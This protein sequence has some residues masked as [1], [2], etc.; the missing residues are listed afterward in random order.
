[1]NDRARLQESWDR[2]RGHLNRAL[3]LLPAVPAESDDARVSRYYELIEHNE[4]ELA[5]DELEGL[6][7]MNS[8]SQ[9]FWS[10]LRDAAQEMGLGGHLARFERRLSERGG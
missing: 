1:M 9:R 2:T 5:L 4:L 7:E 3:V 8:A 6:G 10:H